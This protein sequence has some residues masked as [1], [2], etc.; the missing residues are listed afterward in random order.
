MPRKK[1]LP[2]TGKE[3]PNPDK[4][5]VKKKAYYDEEGKRRVKTFTAYSEDELALKITE[6]NNS[7]V[8][9]KNGSTTVLEAVESYI[10]LREAVL[11]PVTVKQY[12]SI[13]DVH[14]KNDSIGK[15]EIHSLTSPMVQ[16]WINS[17]VDKK[18]KPKTIRNCYGLL[19][20]AVKTQDK[21]IQWGIRLPQA[22]KYQA[23]TPGDKEIKQFIQHIK[24]KD[25]NLYLAVLL[26][27]FGPMRRSEICA[28]TSDDIKG[29]AVTVHRAKVPD[30]G[31]GWVIKDTPK[32]DASNR[33]IAYPAF[34][35]K[36]LKSVSGPVIT[37][38]PAHITKGFK[39]EM[40]NAGLPVCRFHDLRHY[41]ASIMHAIGVPDVYIIERGG[42]SSDYVMKKIY[43]DSLDAEKRKQTN[44]IN[45]HFGKLV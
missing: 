44:A 38:S 19:R 25:R 11:S 8:K 45:K 35:A 13:R 22:A 27:A 7:R 17:L 14:I 3:K 23:N 43:R 42:W 2:F 9:P 10:K 28:L 37:C 31:G 32:T 4:R 41:S 6:W 24:G 20:S 12:Q 39:K 26:A 29:N 18:C 30:V 1:R 34:V 16:A 36:E 33:T 40:K 15:T 21:S 5:I